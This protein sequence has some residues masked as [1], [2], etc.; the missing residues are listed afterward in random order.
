MHGNVWEWCS[1]WYDGKLIGGV[2][3]IGPE[4]GSNRVNRGGCWWYSPDYCRSAFRYGYA[5]SYRNNDVLGFRVARSQ[6]VM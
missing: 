5:P 3:P 2:D 6:S 1:D 4:E